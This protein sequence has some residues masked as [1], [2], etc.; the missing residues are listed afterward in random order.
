MEQRRMKMDR[1]FEWQRDLTEKLGVTIHEL[2]EMP[3]PSEDELDKL[4]DHLE[5]LQAERDKRA[6]LF[7]N[8]QVEIKDIMGMFY[9]DI[10]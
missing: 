5:V 4:K 2:Q 8:T 1:L 9:I 7:L 6:E 10:V 3:L